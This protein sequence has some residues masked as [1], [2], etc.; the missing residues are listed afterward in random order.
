MEKYTPAFEF[1]LKWMPR[2]NSTFELHENGLDKGKIG[3]SQPI[4]SVLFGGRDSFSRSDL[5][6]SPM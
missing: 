2:L 6:E 1:L 4:R 5:F 3:L